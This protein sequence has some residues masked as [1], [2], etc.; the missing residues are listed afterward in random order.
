MFLLMPISFTQDEVLE[1]ESLH[2]RFYNWICAVNLIWLSKVKLVPFT[3]IC[4][5]KIRNGTVAVMYL[6]SY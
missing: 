6:C 3:S 4:G 5:Y 2:S 1:F